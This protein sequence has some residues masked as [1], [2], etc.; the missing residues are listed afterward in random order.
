MMTEQTVIVRLSDGADSCALLLWTGCA[1]CIVLK[2][3]CSVHLLFLPMMPP[4]IHNGMVTS[5]QMTRITTMVP[6]GRACVDCSHR[7]C[8]DQGRG[9]TPTCSCTVSKCQKGDHPVMQA[10][11]AVI[12]SKHL[13]NKNRRLW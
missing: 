10:L 7:H 11:Q 6:N 12:L 3:I 8:E 2:Q 9:A 13:L 5:A 1:V 4:R